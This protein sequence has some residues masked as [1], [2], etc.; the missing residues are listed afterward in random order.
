[1]GHDSPQD[2][3]HETMRLPME[4]TVELL[5]A[6]V[7]EMI[8]HLEARVEKH[9]ESIPTAPSSRRRCENRALEQAVETLQRLLQ[10][11]QSLLT[12]RTPGNH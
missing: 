1:M 5:V 9:R 7:D 10:Y 3:I 8:S 11:R 4:P 6:S 2:F 12:D